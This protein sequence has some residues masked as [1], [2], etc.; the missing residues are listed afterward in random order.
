MKKKLDRSNWLSWMLMLGL[1]AF[2]LGVGFLLLNAGT[3]LPLWAKALL[4]VPPGALLFYI[5]CKW[6]DM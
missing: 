3:S 5:A 4:S 2:F 6:A 1:V